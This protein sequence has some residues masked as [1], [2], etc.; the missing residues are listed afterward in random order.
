MFGLVLV[1]KTTIFITIL[2]ISEQAKKAYESRYISIMLIVN[3]SRF[4]CQSQTI[5]FLI[6]VNSIVNLSQF[7]CQSWTYGHTSIWTDNTSWSQSIWL[8]ISVDSI[9]DLSRFDCWSQSI[10]L[11]ISID[12]IIDLN[13][14]NYWSQS[15][16]L[17]ISIDSIV[18]LCDVFRFWSQMYRHMY[19]QMDN[20]SC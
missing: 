4:D 16:Q 7:Y 3:L 19:G 1:L 2:Y 12:S 10:W 14:F 5:W 6:S 17:L 15:I 13:R 20:T 18:N 11:F 9:V 8:L